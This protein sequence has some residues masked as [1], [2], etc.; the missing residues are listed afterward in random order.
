MLTTF[1]DIFLS[2]GVLLTFGLGSIPEFQYYDIALAFVAVTAIFMLVIVWVPETPRWL[3]TVKDM[4][5]T[6]AVL[7]YL[8]GTQNQQKIAEELEKIKASI[9]SKKLNIFQ[10]LSLIFTRDIRA[11]FLVALFICVFHQLCG[12]A[13]VTNYVGPIYRLAGAQ[14][15]QIL[16]L[17]TVGCGLL[18]ARFLAAVLVELVGRKILLSI[19]AA[20]M[21]SGHAMVGLQFFLRKPSMCA[22]STGV[23]LESTTELCNFHLFPLFYVGITLF[24][25]SFGIGVGPITWV[26]F[27]EYLPLQV[28]G[29]AG[30]IC[31]SASR[32][33]ALILAV[34]FL[35]YSEWAGYWTSW[36]TLSFFNL[37][38]FIVIVLFVVETKGRTLEEVQE[39]F[40]RRTVGYKIVRCKMKT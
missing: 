38:G 3:L 19:S 26:V 39:L 40:R 20:G 25:L 27:S 6:K 5:R 9:P 11:P 12:V 32:F 8:R 37:V 15:A 17:G 4:E 29:V 34:S 18:V 31:V 10:V 24:S 14:N 35:N 13:I 23:M 36:W 21:C 28:R 1:A 22:N 2:F 16:S 30:G 33:T 7:K